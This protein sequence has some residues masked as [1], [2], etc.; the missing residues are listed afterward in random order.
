M[1]DKDL[2]DRVYR[3]RK[4]DFLYISSLPDYVERDERL[5]I[6]EIED[7]WR[8]HLRSSVDERLYLYLNIPFCHRKCHYCEFISGHPG[9]DSDLD[10]YVDGMIAHFHRF[11]DTFKGRSFENLYIGGGTP[12]VLNDRQIDRLLA[13]IFVNF[14]FDSDGMRNCELNPAS[15]SPLKF[16]TLKKRGINRVS[17][18]V[19]S[20]DDEV[21][22]LNNR[23]YQSE[24]SVRRVVADAI[25]AGF[26]EIN[27]DLMFGLYGDDDEKFMESLKKAMDIGPDSICVYL[28]HPKREYL[29]RFGLNAESYFKDRR[30]RLN[31]LRG[32]IKTVADT[33]GYELPLF[34]EFNFDS[35]AS[36]CFYLFKSNSN[37]ERNSD[38]AYTLETSDRKRCSILGIGP[39]SMSRIGNETEYRTSG[40]RIDGSFYDHEINSRGPRDAMT[41]FILLNICHRRELSDGDFSKR[42]GLSMFDEFDREFGELKARELIEISGDKVV[43]NA[44]DYEKRFFSSLFFLSEENLMG[45]IDEGSFDQGDVDKLADRFKGGLSAKSMKRIDRMANRLDRMAE[46]RISGVSEGT[47][48]VD[49]KELFFGD[50]TVCIEICKS[51][52]GSEVYRRDLKKGDILE[53]DGV[54]IFH[55]DGE[56]ML[57]RR[58]IPIGTAIRKLRR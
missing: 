15:S 55:D 41:K 28:F 19:Q 48:S 51:E 43:F 7:L 34:D 30:D 13:E 53:G 10:R 44:D 35:A 36:G 9:T 39:F 20:F 2:I 18:G 4:K 27:L 38:K 24:R 29:E 45:L 22:S 47:I 57:L 26:V 21:L 52:D 46:G 33:N 11:K 56:I 3:E 54:S 17:F 32:R 50:D 1:I 23:E 25:D 37:I 8:E 12:S 42:F 14:S 49:G 58:I 40:Q 16:Q 31:Y 6:S 5:D